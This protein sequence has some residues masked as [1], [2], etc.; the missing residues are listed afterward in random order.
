METGDRELMEKVLR[1]S[2]E[3]NVMLRRM[4]SR[5]RWG[6]IFRTFYWIIIIGLA[7]GAFYFIQPYVETIGT[8]ASQFKTSVETIRS[9]V[10]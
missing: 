1:L 10:N 9:L 5:A 2:Q 4:Q 6:M 7:L 8:G 3:N